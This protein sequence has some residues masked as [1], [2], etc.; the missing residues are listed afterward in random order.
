MAYGTISSLLKRLFK[1]AGIKKKSNPH[2]FRHS[3]ATLMA[4]HLTEFQM[5]QY[6]GWIQGSDMPSTYIHMSGKEV[7]NAILE[8][9]GVKSREEKK[10]SVLRPVKC[11]RCDTINSYNSKYCNKCSGIL[12]LKLAMEIEENRTKE[13]SMRSNSDDVMNLLMKDK[14]VQKLLLE[15]I[16]QLGLGEKLGSLV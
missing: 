15:K 16:T 5:N 4:N 3:R 12:D 1:K 11:P 13:E 8:M 7:D 6:F 2:L 10:E 9:N 14:D